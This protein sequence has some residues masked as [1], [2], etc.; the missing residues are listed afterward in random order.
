MTG[1][2]KIMAVLNGPA[3]NKGVFD[4][5]VKSRGVFNPVVNRPCAF[6]PMDNQSVQYAHSK[7]RLLCHFI[8]T[9]KRG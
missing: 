6:H 7:S 1:I 3:V 4:K 9:V 5:A 8:H 2:F